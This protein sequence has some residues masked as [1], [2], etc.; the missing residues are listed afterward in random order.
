[1]IVPYATRADLCPA[2]LPVAVRS[3]YSDKRR[4]ERALPA[5]FMQRV[6]RVAMDINKPGNIEALLQLDLACQEPFADLDPVH[7]H[8]LHGRAWALQVRLL[9]PFV[10]R[11]VLLALGVVGFWMIDILES[12]YLHLSADAPLARI[13]ENLFEAAR[14]HEEWPGVERSARKNAK[15]LHKRLVREGYFE[16]AG[17]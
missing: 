5:L 14:T 9:D 6:G 8:K 16:T 2:S 7:K 12:G 11:S 3:Y 17:L 15:R 1:M 13:A 10:D 4:V